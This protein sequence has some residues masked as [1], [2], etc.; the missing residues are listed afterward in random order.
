MRALPLVLSI[1]ACAAATASTPPDLPLFHGCHDGFINW[2]KKNPEPEAS[3]LRLVSIDCVGISSDSYYPTSVSPNGAAVQHW[4]SGYIQHFNI[5]PLGEPG[6][7]QLVNKVT[8]R[9]LASHDPS[10][11][12]PD[13][14]AWS[15]DSGALWSVRQA[16]NPSGFA[17]TGLTPI[18]LGL[19]GSIH[20]L[21][22]LRHAAG[23]LDGI[24]WVG[25]E[26]KAVALFGWRG[27]YYK[28]EH[29]DP[30]P[31]LAIIDASTG[32]IL[33]SLPVRTIPTFK[34]R[35]PAYGVTH[36][37]GSATG[38]ILPDGRVR[39]VLHMNRWTERPQ[40]GS[41]KRE[42]IIRHTDFWL[43]WTQGE[44]PQEWR[45]SYAS[46]WLKPAVLSADGS[47][48]LVMRELQ[49]NGVQVF[50]CDDCKVTPP[51]PVTGT[52]A[53]LIDV[54][55]RR[56]LWTLP[57]TATQFWSQRTPPAISP[58]GR[59]GLFQLPPSDMR[60]PIAL[61]DMRNGRIIQTIAPSMVGSYA[62]SFGFTKEGKRVWVATANV[63]RIYSFD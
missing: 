33:D 47:R 1:V 11:A 51:T 54:V 49:P 34:D 62:D 36:S 14:I 12:A 5:A 60:R 37:I 50:D 23:P 48:L 4:S 58:D 52:I 6:G 7:V 19:D 9:T 17:I 59:Y 30:E 57:A 45:D 53:E 40:G 44:A 63:V 21:P 61:V 29:D 2:I 24:M 41:N 55:T 39:T 27:G 38:A 31:T 26:G 20:D 15:V 8:Y 3:P 42:D 28:P 22:L 16:V 46:D 10:G 25:G 35:L 18:K 32:K 43:E 13:A 56:A